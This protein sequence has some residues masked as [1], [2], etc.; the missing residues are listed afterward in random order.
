L[1]L[2]LNIKIEAESL[3]PQLGCFDIVMAQ[4]TCKS[5]YSS[6][7]NFHNLPDPYSWLQRRDHTQSTVKVKR[8]LRNSEIVRLP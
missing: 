8:K 2:G 4:I 7:A 1:T 6:I 3:R 5:L